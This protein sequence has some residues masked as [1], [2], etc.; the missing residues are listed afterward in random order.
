MTESQY[1]ESRRLTRPVP[2]TVRYSFVLWLVAI[3]A[4]VFETTL[5]AAGSTLDGD[6]LAGV[7]FRCAV[8][9][10]AAFAAVRMRA[11]R[12]W[13]RVTLTAVLGILGT[14]SLVIAP[15]M[16]IVDGQ[17]IFDALADAGTRTLL[18]GASRGIHVIAVLSAVGC[19]FRPAANTYF[20][21]GSQTVSMRQG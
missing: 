14:L 16:F 15:V 17:S 13:A 11:G 3:A 18:F 20:H 10:G 2:A 9:G 7:A 19:M 21:R 6:L 8:F 1:A 4:G 12:R 5:I